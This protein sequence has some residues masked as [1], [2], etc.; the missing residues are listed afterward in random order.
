MVFNP[1]K[2]DRP[3]ALTHS[4]PIGSIFGKMAAALSFG[5]ELRGFGTAITDPEWVKLL[6]ACG[7]STSALYSITIGAVTGGPFQHGET[8]TGGTSGKTGRVMINTATG[9]TTLYFIYLGTGS[10]Q[11]GEVLTGS[12]SG[13]TATTGSTATACGRAYNPISSGAPSLTMA[14]YEDGVRKLLKGCRGKFKIDFKAGEPAMMNFDF[15]G[16]KSAVADIAMLAVTHETT[17]PPVFASAA[18]TIDT[19]AAKISGLSLSHDNELTPREDVSDAASLLSYLISDRKISGDFDPEMVTIATKDF[20]AAWF[21]STQM[22]LDFTFGSVAGNKFRFY[23][24]RAQFT[25]LDDEAR[26]GMKIIKSSFDLCGSVN[27][28]NDELTILAL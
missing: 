10:F 22:A 1:T 7:Y 14:T 9:T 13:S 3:P 26:S 28:G 2:Y 21:A 18:L 27:L 6:R 16:V 12:S 8:I 5:I 4:S 20:H 24:P 25:K 23:A 17:I 15:S 11:N 19:Y